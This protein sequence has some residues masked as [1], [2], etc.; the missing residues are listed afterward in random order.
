MKLFIRLCL[1][2][3]LTASLILTGCLKQNEETVEFESVS[4]TGTL[5]NLGEVAVSGKADHILES[6]DGDIHYVYSSFIDL[7]KVK[8]QDV[9][10][11]I[12][13]EVTDRTDSGKE[14][15][16]V[17]SVIP[18]TEE[19]I[20]Q[21]SKDETPKK[22]QNVEVGFKLEGLVGWS[23][24][25][26]ANQ[27]TLTKDQAKFTVTRLENESGLTLDEWLDR[28]N[29]S[30]ATPVFIGPD[31]LKAYLRESANSPIYFISRTDKYV[32]EVRLLYT[33]PEFE[34]EIKSVLNSF[35]FIP[36]V[37]VKA[38]D[39]DEKEA[40]VSDNV[41]VVKKYFTNNLADLAPDYGG[42]DYEILQFEFVTEPEESEKEY[43]YI[44]YSDGEKRIRLLVS[45]KSD[46]GVENVSTEAVFEEGVITDWEIADGE[47]KAKG[48]P[49]LIVKV[50]S[51]SGPIAL[52][53]GYRLFES[54]PFDFTVQYPS[55]WYVQGQSGKYLFNDA[56]LNGTYLISV[57]VQRKKLGDAMADIPFTF[58]SADL[59]T[60]RDAFMAIPAKPDEH[61]IYI[62]LE[63]NDGEEAYVLWGM[64]SQKEVLEKMAISIMEN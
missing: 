6:D 30:K 26:F 5:K 3:A 54:G 21:D 33:D 29:M 9:R 28:N 44:V 7:D 27:V 45:Y 11:Q 34:N 46:K 25:E 31:K 18:L 2:L 59:R 16:A 40:S 8:Y 62:V 12:N 10:V 1:C 57:E 51:S 42:S 4:Y 53:E 61:G 60:D 38:E 52:E 55:N 24:E 47:D 23:I 56:P 15:I 13:G 39:K 32:Y 35:R 48:L 22:Y 41:D 64:Q 36:M 43:L 17:E 19:V 63:R 58:E 37:E 49:T 50:G 20:E 14:I